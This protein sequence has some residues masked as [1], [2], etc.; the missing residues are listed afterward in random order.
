MHRTAHGCASREVGH[1]RDDLQR[2]LVAG[3]AQGPRDLRHARAPHPLHHL[4]GAPRRGTHAV[5]RRPQPCRPL[6]PAAVPD[7]WL[8]AGAEGGDHPQDGT[9]GRLLDRSGDLG[10]DG[11]HCLRRDPLRSDGEH[12]RGRDPAPVDRLPRLCALRPCRRLHRHLRNRAR[13]LVFGIDVPASRRPALIGA[14]DFLRAR[15]VHV[16]RRGLPVRRLDVHLGDRGRPGTDLVRRDPAAV[17][18]HLCD[19][20]GGRDQPRT[21]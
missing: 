11:L 16:L 3:A 4:V 14:D 9:S 21:V 12:L 15:D 1:D 8:Q 7:G 19:G 5:A 13:R 20:D 18:P 10:D 17:L 6:R 2:P